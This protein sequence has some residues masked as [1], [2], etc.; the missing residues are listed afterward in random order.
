MNQLAL[1]LDPPLARTR[2]PATSHAAASRAREFAANHEALCF[3]V[4]ADMDARGAT[5]RDIER[6]TRLDFVQANRRLGAMGKRGLIA[7]R[8]IGWKEGKR[9][10][11]PDYAERDGCCIWWKA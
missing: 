7:R 5:A 3:G 1:S 4:I 9:G 10:T 6:Y 8:V 11:M 2:D